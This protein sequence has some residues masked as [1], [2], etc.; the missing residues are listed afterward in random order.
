MTEAAPA[1]VVTIGEILVEVMAVERGQGFLV[2]LTLRGPFPSG[3]PAIFIDQVAKLG[4]ACAMVSCVGDDDFGRLNLA[5]L[6]RDGVGT[7]AVEVLA[8]EVTGSAFVRY[9][10]DGG[11]DFV[12]NLARSAAGR[13]R[14]SEAASQVLSACNHL[15]ISGS[16]LSATV[17]SE[18]VLG[19]AEAMKARGGT[20]SFDPNV[21]P[22][23]AQDPEIF[24]RLKRA[25]RASDVFLP[26]GHE[27]TLLT[28]ASDEAE[29]EAIDE[30]LSSGVSCVVVKRGVEGSTY[31]DREGSFSVPAFAVEEVDP[32][33][34][35]DCFD[36]AFVTSWLRRLAPRDCLEI[37][38]A[39][40]ARAVTVL[41]PMEGTSTMAEIEELRS[42]GTAA[43]AAALTPTS[44]PCAAPLPATGRPPVPR[45]V[46]RLDGWLAQHLSGPAPDGLTSVCSAHEVVLEA[47]MVQAAATGTAVLIEATCNQVN[48]KGGYTGL[49]PADFRD[50]TGTI[51]ERSGLPRER[52]LLGGD[53]LGPNPWRSLPA[54]QAMAEAEEMVAAYTSAAYEKLHIDTSM[55]CRGEP[56]QLGDEQTAERAARLVAVAEKAAGT[57]GTQPYYVIGTEVPSP[58][59]IRGEAGEAHVT[60]PEAVLATLDAHRQAFSRAGVEPAFDRVIAVVAH[61][62]VEFDNQKIFVYRPERAKELSG[63][64]AKMPG[65][66]FEAHSTDYQPA[67]GLARLVQDGFAVLKVGPGLT[68]AMREALYGLDAAA[69]WAFPGWRDRS[70]AV[71]VEE[72]M[73]AHPENW[74]A[75]Y[76]GGPDHQRLLRHFS[77]SD[78]VRYYWAFPRLREGIQSLYAQFG[79]D[80]VPE[81]LVSQFLPRLYDRVASGAIAATPGALV[82]ES[83][84]D[85]L[86][87]YAAACGTK[88]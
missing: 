35:G 37:A 66:V 52:L 77:Y 17:A 30:I 59:G 9:R 46:R 85:V 24:S 51:A 40:G 42:R 34:A 20:V 79:D 39:A 62:G 16:S 50:M 63:A 88:S 61:P 36:A 48:H 18:L 44:P 45:R 27:V 74:S 57:L 32:T 23:L 26:S 19:S 4:Q 41:G 56:A 82:T 21:R 10:D 11:R 43:P 81:T 49:T 71:A 76:P 47:S 25:L 65:L 5:R 80:P 12:F 38:N 69:C 55:G 60:S 70:L 22:E 75:Y 33:G 31:H 58:G 8:G 72:E 78:R 29:A 6:E 15:H 68:F 83:V 53:H 87:A 67:S 13:L 64:L 3:A 54:E 28:S 7:Q 1:R 84:R 2:P 73:L 14:G 86:R